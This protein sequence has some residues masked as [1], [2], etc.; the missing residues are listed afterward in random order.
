MIVIETKR[1]THQESDSIR[2]SIEKNV[3]RCQTFQQISIHLSLIQ[4]IQL[5]EGQFVFVHVFEV[6]EYPIVVFLSM[7]L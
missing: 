5:K 3:N 2:D 7:S 1:N 6:N 4:R